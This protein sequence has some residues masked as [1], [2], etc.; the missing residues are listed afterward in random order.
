MIRTPARF[1]ER[2]AT[3]T[4]QRTVT[5]DLRDVRT[6]GRT[7]HGFAA[8]YG[9]E[10]R[11]IEDRQL[12]RF[13]EVIAPGAFRDVL[14]ADS[15]VILCL[16]HDQS[17]MLARTTS[18]TLRI[19]DEERGL[20][21]E[22]DLG[23]G[24]TADDVRSMVRRGD[25]SGMS[26]RFRAAADGEQWAGEQRTLTRIEHLADLSLATTPAYSGPDGPSVEL[27]SLPE[28]RQRPG[29]L[30]VGARGGLTSPAATETRTSAVLRTEERM[31]DWQARRRTRSSFT[32]EEAREFSLGRAVKGMVTGNWSEA[33]LERRA[34]AE[35]A[36][37]TGGFLTPELVSAQVIDRIRAQA[38][39]LNAGATVVPMDSDQVSVPRLAAGITAQWKVEN[40]AVQESDPA[41]ERVT[42]VAKTLPVLTR[43]SLELFED[44]TPAASDAITGELTSAIALELDRAAL[45]GSGVA[46]IPLG[47]RNQPGVELRAMT[48]AN[49][50]APTS[51][52]DLVRAVAALRGR[53]ISPNAVLHSPRTAETYALL[54]A[55]DGQP[56][57]PPAY[58]S[59]LTFLETSQVPNTLTTGTS[60]DTSEVYI[61]RW[62]DL[63]IGVRPSIGVRVRQLNERYADQMQVGLL[64]WLRADV[65]LAHPESFSIL[66]GVRP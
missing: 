27:R 13:T 59:G 60:S 43:V 28:Q 50:S 65:Q 8:L 53:N 36:G 6:E 45:R 46:P 16:N 51:Y 40:A 11:P 15:D 2:T 20:R 63:L 57:I 17:R 23:D 49:G 26:F 66:T 34:L 5:A 58:L 18:G 48:G 37:S 39:V 54:A 9:V 42:L 22:A 19:F 44:M 10:S 62:S 33:D 24:P 61:G 25:L 41:F 12:G 38:Q 30:P 21:F 3:A 29:S 7:L 1:E 31:L 47:L 14:G 4:E 52:A 56:L 35:G 55:T 32:A 64:A